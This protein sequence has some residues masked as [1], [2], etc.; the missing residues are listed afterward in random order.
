VRLSAAKPVF[1]MMG[2]IASRVTSCGLLREGHHEVRRSH[3]LALVDEGIS[4]QFMYRIVKL[5]A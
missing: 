2:E 4:S 1:F 3:F 5:L